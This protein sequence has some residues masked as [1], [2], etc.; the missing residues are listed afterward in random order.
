MWL[1]AKAILSSIA[2][3][4]VSVVLFMILFQNV[5]LGFL[6]IV[7]IGLIVFSDIIIGYQ[8]TRNHLRW[9]IDPLSPSEEIC[10]LFDHSGNVDFVRTKKGPYDTRQFT[11][12]GKPATIVNTGS[13]QIRTHNGNKGFVGHEDYEMNVNPVECGAL[14]QCD[15][16]NV[17]EIYDNLP[18]KV[19][20]K[21]KIRF[22][23]KPVKGVIW[24]R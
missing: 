22:G 2:I 19:R 3:I 11:R 7:A 16:D 18:H 13:Y 1:E 9:L 8:I 21:K 17:I 5:L 15:G 23:K 24:N 10:I 20:S 14:E 12:Y 4:M 6:L